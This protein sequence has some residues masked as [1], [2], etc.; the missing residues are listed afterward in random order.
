MG[1]VRIGPLVIDLDDVRAIVDKGGGVEVTYRDGTS[2][3][4]EGDHADAL[5]KYVL[6]LPDG[7]PLYGP[8]DAVMGRAGRVED[9][10]TVQRKEGN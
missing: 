10:P 7:I 1:L 5:R 9:P 8:D 6:N 3:F 2:M 4:F